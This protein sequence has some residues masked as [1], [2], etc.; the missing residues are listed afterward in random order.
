MSMIVEYLHFLVLA[1]APLRTIYLSY[2]NFC[3]L[4]LFI[5]IGKLDNFFLFFL[6]FLP[7]SPKFGVISSK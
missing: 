1:S 6:F 3:L 2:Y 5:V 7:I 4:R